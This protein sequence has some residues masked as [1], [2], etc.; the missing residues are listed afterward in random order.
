[1]YDLLRALAHKAG[2]FHGAAL[3]R[4]TGYG[5]K[6]VRSELKKLREI[7][8][9]EAAGTDGRKELLRLAD[10]PLTDTVLELPALLEARLEALKDAAPS[11]DCG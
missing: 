8:M 6:Q 11:A 1:M 9:V 5:R 2:S 4:E 10:D 7:G 3:A